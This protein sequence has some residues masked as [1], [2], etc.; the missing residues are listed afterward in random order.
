MELSSSHTLHSEVLV[1]HVN[2]RLT[3]HGRRLIVDRVAASRSHR[4]CPIRS[5][6]RRG[7]PGRRGNSL[8]TRFGGEPAVPGCCSPAVG[9]AGL[10]AAIQH[11][12]SVIAARSFERS[13]EGVFLWNRVCNMRSADRVDQCADAGDGDSCLVSLLDF[14]EGTGGAGHH[15]VASL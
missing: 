9:T 6:R 1:S 10:L 5:G 15:N 7:G 2:A 12:T 3:V 14:H 13:L 4:S 11:G 8:R